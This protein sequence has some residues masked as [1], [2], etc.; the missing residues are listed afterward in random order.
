M[1]EHGYRPRV[2]YLVDFLRTLNAGT[3]R[4]LGYLLDHLPEEGF[5]L[6]LISL[7][8]SPLLSHEIGGRFPRV[9]FH[10]LGGSSDISA[11]LGAF[12]RLAR[13]L[14]RLRPDLVHTFFPAANSLG[15]LVARMAGVRAILSSRRDM[16]YHLTRKDIWGLKI[17]NPL[18]SGVIANSGAVRDKVIQMEGLSAERVTVIHNGI[19]LDQF[20]EGVPMAPPDPPVVGIVANLNRRVKRVDLF[21]R[22]AAQVN[23]S[24]PD[25]TFRVI[26]DGCLRPE[27]EA[28]AA[29]LGIAAQVEFLG[30]RE[31]IRELLGTMSVAV[32]C[33]DSEGFSNALME[34]MLAGLPVVATNVGGN[35]ELIEDG[36]TGLLV[37]VGD[38]EALARA[39][40][41]LLDDEH[42]A[43]ELGAAARLSIESGY[44]IERMV[45]ATADLYRRVVASA[46][47]AT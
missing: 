22:A 31:D 24:H 23:R 39:I 16:G 46:K 43:A 15:V 40:G 1:I 14:R 13:M 32:L 44:S 27:L 30:R 47:T 5:Q 45:S 34:Y 41:R 18:V 3:E 38:A 19:A 37:P 29:S 28:L 7:Q 42:L 26:G 21:V 4:Q 10:S 11:S 2:T 36:R 33:S 35:P 20:S 12:W 25:V 6:S 17:A 9:A 8:D